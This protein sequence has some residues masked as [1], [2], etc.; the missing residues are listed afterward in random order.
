MEEGRKEG[1]RR[2]GR[3]LLRKFLVDG[4]AYMSLRIRRYNASWL[5]LPLSG[6]IFCSLDSGQCGSL[7]NAAPIYRVKDWGRRV[8][9]RVS[10][11]SRHVNSSPRLPRGFALSHPPPVPADGPLSVESRARDC[12]RARITRVYLLCHVHATSGAPLQCDTVWWNTIPS[13]FIFLLVCL[14]L[15]VCRSHPLHPLGLAS[16]ISNS[17]D[18]TV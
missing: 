2:R 5:E 15:R 3:L 14:C 17:T 18:R 1:R 7:C 16:L 10:L 6:E 4:L 11:V 12:R 8:A 13:S 9:L